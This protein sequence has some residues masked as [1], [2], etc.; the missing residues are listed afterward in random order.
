MIL[1]DVIKRCLPKPASIV[2]R[3]RVW[4]LKSAS[5][6]DVVGFGVQTDPIVSLIFWE[7]KIKLKLRA[8][9]RN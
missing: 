3:M 5:G 2:D 9:D 8:A 4:Y 7:Y 1:D 6:I